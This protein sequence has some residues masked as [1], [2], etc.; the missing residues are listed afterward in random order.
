MAEA[1]I[2]A[3][4]DWVTTAEAARAALAQRRHDLCFA[5]V[6]A[7]HRAAPDILAW[8]DL[9]PPVPIVVLTDGAAS[10]DEDAIMRAGATEVLD[11]ET[12]VP[13]ALGRVVR[14]LLFRE[15]RARRLRDR[16]ERLGVTA[17]IAPAGL[18]YVDPARRVVLANRRAAAWLGRG[19]GAVAGARLA[20]LL[21]DDFTRIEP[22]VDA[23][24][25]GQT[26]GFETELRQAGHG[27]SRARVRLVPDLDHAGQAAGC[28]AFIEDAAGSE[29]GA[30]LTGGEERLRDFALEAS[31]W[32]WETDP[33]HRL[34]YLSASVERHVGRGADRLLGRSIA[35]ALDAEDDA[36]IE[37]LNRD[38][39]AGRPIADAVVAFRDDRQA[40]RTALLSGRPLAAPDGS[41]LGY[42][43][44]GRDITAEVRAAGA[45]FDA[46]DRLAG[47]AVASLTRQ[48][49]GQGGLDE[50]MPEV[51]AELV[52]E[53][54]IEL[55]RMA[56]V[57]E[58]R[59]I[60]P[61]TPVLQDL[62]QRLGFLRATARDVIR[63]HR[64]ALGQRLKLA[65]PEPTRRMLARS[66]LVLIAALTLLVGHFRA[67][68]TIERID[69]QPAR[70]KR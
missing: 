68:A 52:A 11:R 44:I 25:R 46:L 35:G 4:L 14:H 20:D 53:Y 30:G 3:D 1:E 34:V 64:A 19:G 50:T 17:D 39:A 33:E 41:F 67:G 58:D 61:M 31:E 5:T 47:P 29:R 56:T 12:L 27:L 43:G 54:G 7:G 9:G 65:A 28:V 69:A 42:R 22:Y 13:G 60:Q 36:G 51:F 62:I 26:V 2:E 49:F 45:E 57:P 63:V 66:R 59:T 40:A 23:A 10:D 55:E 37:A 6:R 32:L 24:L 48:A 18:A 38:M 16:V 8:D 15:E 70:A 21:G